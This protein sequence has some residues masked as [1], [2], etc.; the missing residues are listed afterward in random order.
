M[1]QGERDLGQAHEGRSRRSRRIPRQPQWRTARRTAGHPE[2]AAKGKTLFG[3]GTDASPDSCFGCHA[4][5][6]DDPYFKDLGDP[7]DTGPE[8]TGYASAKWLKE[9]ILAPGHKRF[10]GEDNAMA[11]FAGKL[12][13][14]ELDMLVMWMLGRWERQGHGP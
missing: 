12:T 10:Y 5:K 9:F 2:L 14:R 3:E 11:P 8:L 1:G 4:I 7:G 6:G 13:D